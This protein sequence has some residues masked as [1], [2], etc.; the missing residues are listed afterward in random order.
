MKFLA[1]IILSISFNLVISQNIYR[2]GFD[3]MIHL[4]N[5]AN[6]NYKPA[7]D[8]AFNYA[9]LNANNASFK[10]NEDEVLRIP[11]VVHIVY[12]TSQQNLPDSLVFNQIDILNRDFNRKSADTVNE[13][14][15]FTGIPKIANIEFY[16]ACIDPNGDPTTG[17]T[18]T[19]TNEDAF[20]LDLF[21]G[22]TGGIDN[23]KFDSTGGSSA[24][25]VN[26]YL[27]IWVCNTVDANSFFGA[28]LGLAYP[29]Q[30]APNWPPDA[31]PADE[32]IQ[33]VV[34]HYEVFGFP[35]P[36]AVGDYA[37]ADQGRTVIHEVG[38]YLGLR[39]IWGD[40][41]AAIF[42][43]VDCN[44]TDGI[45]DTPRAGNNSQ[46]DGCD[47]SKNTCNDV[48]N[49]LP[50][51]WENFMDYASETCQTIFTAGQVDIMRSSLLNFR[52][53]L[54]EPQCVDTTN[55]SFY[56]TK[57]NLRVSI[58]PNPAND[59]LNIDFGKEAG[60][61]SCSIINSIGL[62]VKNYPFENSQSIKTVD[63]KDLPKGVYFLKISSSNKQ[64]I[65]KI[66]IAE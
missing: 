42:G 57:N 39:H 29:P 30:G 26:K 56:E 36:F 47:P 8:A 14:N 11:V 21:G 22:G 31:F 6:S 23:V 35:N 50:D 10:T 34:I 40:G 44:A 32:R 33:G 15:I 17:I 48:A 20:A 59:K 65:K 46:V 12:K 24:W 60:Y 19:Q 25:D 7:I 4:K 62:L 53:G 52:S 58:Y 45:D 37:I 54:L 28:V 1:T 27:N 55:T 9:K 3:E 51:M 49:D 16:L 63:V 18:R 5:Q 64:A 66:F 38:H 41:Q 43:G 61:Y 2:C 13:R